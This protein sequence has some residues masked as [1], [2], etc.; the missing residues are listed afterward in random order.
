M[1]TNPITLKAHT[2]FVNKLY[3]LAG[4]QENLPTMLCMI[5]QSNEDVVRQK[6]AGN[7]EFTASEMTLIQDNFKSAALLSA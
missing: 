7:V 6:L 5:L 2:R 3:S 4:P 1:S